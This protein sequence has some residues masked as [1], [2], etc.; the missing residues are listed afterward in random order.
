VKVFREAGFKE[1]EAGKGCPQI[2]REYRKKQG[3]IYAN[4]CE[5]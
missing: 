2:L 3:R 4:I 5:H 1:E